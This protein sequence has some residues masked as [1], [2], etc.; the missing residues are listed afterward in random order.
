MPKPRTIKQKTT[1]PGRKSARP[2]V[3]RV[4]AWL[5]IRLVCSHIATAP[6]ARRFSM[7]LLEPHRAEPLRP[8]PPGDQIRFLVLERLARALQARLDRVLRQGPSGKGEGR[9]PSEIERRQ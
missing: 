1:T 5:K 6:W 2:F 8:S 9:E 4:A 3:I 7:A